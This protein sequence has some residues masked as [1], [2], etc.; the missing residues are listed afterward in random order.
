MVLTRFW[1]WADNP[2]FAQSTAYTSISAVDES[3]AV[4]VH[5]RLGFGWCE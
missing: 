4:V 3:T 5:D 2:D 1:V